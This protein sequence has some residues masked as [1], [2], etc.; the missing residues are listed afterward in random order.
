MATGEK[1]IILACDFSNKTETMRFLS[2]FLG[3]N[4]FVK[5]GME[6]FYGEGPSIV[7]EIKRMNF[8]IFL[9]LKLH[10]TPNT[11]KKAM[12][13]IAKL[14]VDMTTI[15]AA[16]GKQ[17]ML[18]AK[19]GLSSSSASSLLLAVTVLTSLSA[20]IFKQELLISHPVEEVVVHYAKN[21]QS[22]GVDGVVC[23]PL[24]AKTVK[25]ACGNDF[26]TVTP[27]IRYAETGDDQSRVATPSM[28]KTLGS[29]FIVVGRPI[30][31]A[32]D[33]VAAYNRILTDFLG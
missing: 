16:G 33:P 3:Q 2:A 30:T 28:A 7:E 9:D 13:N 26:V 22:S 19:E 10:D 6:L 29:D 5:I 15:H 20:K 27:G 24:E 8:R 23:S 18:A 12:K 21:A 25:S 31:A 11:V 1:G 14:G 17:M 4:I 32:D